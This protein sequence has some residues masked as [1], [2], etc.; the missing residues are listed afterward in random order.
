MMEIDLALPFLD[1]DHPTRIF[2]FFDNSAENQRIIKL[3]KLLNRDFSKYDLTHKLNYSNIIYIYDYYENNLY[4]GIHDISSLYHSYGKS[5]FDHFYSNYFNLTNF[6]N[7]LKL[8]NSSTEK[9]II[10]ACKL[11]RIKEKQYNKQIKQNYKYNE[12]CYN[13]K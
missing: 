7:N 9:R 10:D 12:R 5:S 3:N 11:R 13:K 4:H 8:I 2:Y 6:Y 1:L